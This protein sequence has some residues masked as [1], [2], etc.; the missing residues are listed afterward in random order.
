MWGSNTR[1]DLKSQFTLKPDPRKKEIKFKEI[2]SSLLRNIWL[3]M[4]EMHKT[5]KMLLK[6]NIFHVVVRKA[7]FK[8]WFLIQ[9]LKTKSTLGHLTEKYLKQ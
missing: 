1:I 9:S 2:I 5:V 7:T 4:S 6:V 8:K 3:N